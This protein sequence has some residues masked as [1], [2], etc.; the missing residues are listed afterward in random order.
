MTYVDS[1]S[2]RRVVSKPS[3]TRELEHFSVVKRE[4]DTAIRCVQ[5][6]VDTFR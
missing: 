4:P 2:A 1:K 5:Y 3:I 6:V